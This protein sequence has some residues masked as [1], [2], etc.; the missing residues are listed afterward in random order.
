VKSRSDSVNRYYDPQAGQ[1]I[2][3]DPLVDQTD[4]PYSYGADDPIDNIDPAGLDACL[5]GVCLP[6]PS[7]QDVSDAAAGFGDTLTFGG[8]E[9]I[10]QWLGIDDVVNQCSG[11]YN[12]GGLA[13]AGTTLALGGYGAIT[14]AGEVGGLLERLRSIDWADE[15]GSFNPFARSTEE[16][17]RLDP[18]GKVHG[19]LPLQIPSEWTTSDLEEFAQDLRTSIQTRENEALRLGEDGPHRARIYEERQLLRQIEKRL[20]GS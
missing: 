7:L 14:D 5:F 15:T 19:D 11:W 1:F 2:S 9:I 3:V 17:P 12:G 13:A 8:T 10:R 20:S 4:Q 16:L 18:T 6:A